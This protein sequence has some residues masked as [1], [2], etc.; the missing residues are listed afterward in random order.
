MFGLIGTV[1]VVA[2]MAGLAFGYAAQPIMVVGLLGAAAWI[3]HAYTKRDGWLALVN[4][5]VA[6]FAI[7]G[8]V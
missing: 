7:Y 4:S 8:L 6:G 1:L 2:Q 3:V 5:S